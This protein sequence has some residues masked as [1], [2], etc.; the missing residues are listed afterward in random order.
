MVED[1]RHYYL[2]AVD[3]FGIASATYEFRCRDDDEAKARAQTYL[4][5]HDNVEL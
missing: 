1:L 3:A 2:F 4:E 5:H